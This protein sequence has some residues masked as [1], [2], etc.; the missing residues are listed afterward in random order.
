ML[1]VPDQIDRNTLPKSKLVPKGF[2]QPIPS[3]RLPND[4]W[5]FT[6]WILLNAFSFVNGDPGSLVL[7]KRVVANLQPIPLP[8]N[9]RLK[10]SYAFLYKQKNWVEKVI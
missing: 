10:F 8:P 5:H 1:G 6:Q 2:T 9:M 7:M 3:S 4:L